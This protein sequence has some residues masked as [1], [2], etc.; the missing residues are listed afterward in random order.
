MHLLPSKA[1]TENLEHPLDFLLEYGKDHVPHDLC[2]AEEVSG[3]P[4]WVRGD[5]RQEV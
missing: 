3:V 2:W 1:G 5:W 4:H